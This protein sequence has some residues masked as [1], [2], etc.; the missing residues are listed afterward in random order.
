M[1]GE[2]RAISDGISGFLDEILMDTGKLV[3]GARLALPSGQPSERKRS[4]GL[5][6]G[7]KEAHRDEQPLALTGK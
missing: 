1:A 3:H 4:L 6:L 7:T 2:D 5:A